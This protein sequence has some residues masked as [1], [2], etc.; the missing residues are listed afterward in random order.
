[1]AVCLPELADL[2]H[3]VNRAKTTVLSGRS[4]MQLLNRITATVVEHK[5]N[6]VGKHDFVQFM[7]D[8]ELQ[9]NDE[10]ATE[11]GS[12]LT[13]NVRHTVKPGDVG[14]RLCATRSSSSSRAVTRRP[15]VSPT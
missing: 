2:W 7:L 1:M 14:R 8:A 13:H 10:V 5:E 11:L 3:Y 6:G 12:H 15:S 9:P 4:V